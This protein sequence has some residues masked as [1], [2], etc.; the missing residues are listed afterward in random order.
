[1]SRPPS[2]DPR[3]NQLIVTDPATDFSV[4][5]NISTRVAPPRVNR[6]YDFDWAS[7]NAVA[8]DW[9]FGTEVL[10][11]YTVGGV[12]RRCRPNRPE[13]VDYAAL[14]WFYK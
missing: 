8:G 6:L 10:R 12:P 14:Y 1:M 5:L 11:T 7:F 3:G 2:A 9:D 13:E 4:T